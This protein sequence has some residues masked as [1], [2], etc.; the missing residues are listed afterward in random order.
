MD[1]PGQS[2][3][4]GGSVE[5][6]GNPVKGGA[7]IGYGQMTAV[8][9]DGRTGAAA[10]DRRHTSVAATG[11]VVGNPNEGEARK[12]KGQVHPTYSG[13]AGRVNRDKDRAGHVAA[14]A[15]FK[16]HR[17]LNLRLE[18]LGKG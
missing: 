11:G 13:M 3:L 9:F 8:D 6:S 10:A 17:S 5:K 14:Q 4:D 7:V 2:P 12:F 15:L 16:L 18:R 1:T